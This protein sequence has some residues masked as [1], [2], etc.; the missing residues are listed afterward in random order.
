MDG[1]WIA[2]FSSSG[3][4]SPYDIFRGWTDDAHL[5]FPRYPQG[6]RVLGHDHD[7]RHYPWTPKSLRQADLDGRGRVALVN[8]TEWTGISFIFH[9]RIEAEA[10]AW[11][12]R[13]HFSDLELHRARKRVDAGTLPDIAA[14]AALIIAADG[15]R[16]LRRAREV[17]MTPQINIIVDD[18][19]LSD[20]IVSGLIAPLRHLLEARLI[21]IEPVDWKGE[22]AV[23]QLSTRRTSPRCR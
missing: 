14:A 15:E 4:V 11:N 17:S 13:A 3:D 23:V 7:L 5:V 6:L 19:G 2:A 9:R 16:M 21:R 22:P 8:A 18:S 10:T 12:L 1:R 20:E